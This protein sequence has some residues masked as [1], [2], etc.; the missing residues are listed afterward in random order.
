MNAAVTAPKAPRRDV[1]QWDP[2]LPSDK[3]R[4]VLERI[5]A[6]T[7]LDVEAIFDDLDAAIGD[8]APL[9]AAT[10]ALVERLR[11]HLKRLSDI[12]VAHS[13]NPVPAE[14]EALVERGRT[15]R[16]EP[17]L[18]DHRQA[19]G[20]ARRLGFVVADLVEALIEARCIKG[21]E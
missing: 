16:D 19:V 3:L 5:T 7:P 21:G 4:F 20:L 12:A 17:L 15:I 9:P 10:A 13:T 6:W 1:P 2:P 18:A 8:Q 11:G 14:M